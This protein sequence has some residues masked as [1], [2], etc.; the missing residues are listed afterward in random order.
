MLGKALGRREWAWSGRKLLTTIGELQRKLEAQLPGERERIQHARKERGHE[1]AASVS[2]AQVLGG[3]RDIPSLV[4][5]ISELKA[6]EGIR[7]RGRPLHE[8]RSS[9]ASPSSEPTS[10]SVLWLLLVGE[11]P[12]QE[13]ERALARDLKQREQSLV[14]SSNRPELNIV[15]NMASEGSHPMS[16]LSAALLSLQRFSSFSRAYNEGVHKQSL[17]EYA[18]EDGL[19]LLASVPDVA[20]H[21]YKCTYNGT[22]GLPREEADRPDDWASRFARG[23]G[24]HSNAATNYM[25]LYAFLHCEHQVGNA[26][27]H[28]SYLISSTLAD[29]YLAMSAAVNALAGPLHGLAN[30]EVLSFIDEKPNGMSMREHAKKTMASGRV[31]P[32]YGHGALRCEDPRFTIQ[33]QFAREND[34]I[35]KNDKVQQAEAMYQEVPEFL[36]STGK[37]SNPQPN[38]DAM[39]GSIL[40]ALGLRERTYYTAVFAVARSIGVVAQVVQARKLGLPIERPRSVTLEELLSEAEAKR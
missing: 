36:R 2:V 17:W 3:M 9:L 7:Y 40:S 12:S 29:P 15:D 8:L 24:L 4:S 11:A 21:V 37:V 25:R 31:I 35:W 38:T 18:L 6:D 5:D 23:L 22:G 19:N 32:G 1:V 13:Q 27:T 16:Q 20:S 34:L 14:Q 33:R 26:S 10:E 28:A 39:S 30:Q